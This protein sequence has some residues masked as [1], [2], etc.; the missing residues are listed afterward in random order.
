[1]RQVHP[2]LGTRGRVSA[3]ERTLVIP[4]HMKEKVNTQG[5]HRLD[6]CVGAMGEDWGWLLLSSSP[7]SFLFLSLS[8]F[9]GN[10]I[11]AG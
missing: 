11:G 6:T 8:I 4:R 5:E 10:G 2:Y 3:I 9:L 1:M 7:Y